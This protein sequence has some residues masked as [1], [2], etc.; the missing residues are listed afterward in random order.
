MQFRQ[1]SVSY[2]AHFLFPAHQFQL[3][4]GVELKEGVRNPV[5]VFL[6][7]QF[8]MN[9]QRE[10][11]PCLS[12]RLLSIIF[13]CQ[14]LSDIRQQCLQV[15]PVTGKLNLEQ[16]ILLSIPKLTLCCEQVSTS[17]KNVDVQTKVT[18][19]Y[20]CHSLLAPDLFFLILSR[21]LAA[22][23]QHLFFHLHSYIP[24]K[25]RSFCSRSGKV[26]FNIAAF[27]LNSPHVRNL[28]E[29]QKFSVIPCFQNQSQ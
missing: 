8:H 4:T 17:L 19:L 12:A 20:F 27:Y 26:R 18:A 22:P 25:S 3:L 28:L 14:M 29:H 11:V 9:K 21:L 15:L 5:E 23:H 10:G 1:G 7:S 2:F 13:R 24:L 16:K 6:S